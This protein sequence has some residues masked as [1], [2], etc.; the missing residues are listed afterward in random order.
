[1]FLISYFENIAIE[2]A[3]DIEA[4]SKHEFLIWS[5][6]YNS[7]T[8]RFAEAAMA[9]QIKNNLLLYFDNITVA[10]IFRG[11]ILRSQA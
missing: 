1:L 7:K 10:P 5:S 8:I 4:A 6:E 2:Y 3:N 9:T 11:E